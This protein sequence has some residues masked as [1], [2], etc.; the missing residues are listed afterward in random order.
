MATKTYTIR[1]KKDLNKLTT[2]SKEHYPVYGFSNLTF[3]GNK[4]TVEGSDM[5]VLDFGA[6]FA[7]RN[8]S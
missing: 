5:G 7:A 2:M 8:K 6:R 4:V 1:S 3:N